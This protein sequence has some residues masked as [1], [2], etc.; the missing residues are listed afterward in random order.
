[1]TSLN[2]IYDKESTSIQVMV[3]DDDCGEYLTR[4]GQCPKCK[5]HPD[6]QSTAFTSIEYDELQALIYRG[7]SFL[8]INRTPIEGGMD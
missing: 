8:G 2:D 4:K 1:M 3:H 5:F 7:R 6:M